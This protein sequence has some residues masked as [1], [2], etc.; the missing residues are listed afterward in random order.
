[1]SEDLLE[2]LRALPTVLEGANFIWEK[3]TSFRQMTW[4]TIRSQNGL[5]VILD[6]VTSPLGG[7]RR[8]K[9]VRRRLPIRPISATSILT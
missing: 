3:Q 2:G 6:F 7:V 4:D 5:E 9:K 1:M 8:N